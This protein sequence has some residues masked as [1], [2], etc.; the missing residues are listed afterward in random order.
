MI[1]LA[2][3][4]IKGKLRVTKD[5]E[6]LRQLDYKRIPAPFIRNTTNYKAASDNPDLMM[7]RIQ[8]LQS[9]FI[10]I[11]DDP[12]NSNAVIIPLHFLYEALMKTRKGF[13]MMLGKTTEA[14]AEFM[15]FELG[16][17]DC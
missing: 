10:V 12:S 13:P 16:L 6:L 9:L 8:I 3:G 5:L 2:G 7:D 1:E 11:D 14:K 15:K 4:E 17:G